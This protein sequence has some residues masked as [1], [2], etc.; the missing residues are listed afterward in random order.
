VRTVV[1]RTLRS[2]AQSGFIRRELGRVVITDREGM[3]TVV[4]G[5][6]VEVMSWYDNELGFTSHMIREGVRIAELESL[7]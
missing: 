1:G 2:F 6:L 4:D 3:T 7:A 5:T